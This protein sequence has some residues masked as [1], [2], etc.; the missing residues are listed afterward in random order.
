MRQTLL[1]SVAL[2][3]FLNIAISA[4]EN[5]KIS[6]LNP[7]KGDSIIYLSPDQ[8]M[9]ISKE[10]NAYILKPYY[11]DAQNT[12]DDGV[13]L[14]V[15]PNDN[16]ADAIEINEVHDIPISTIDATIDGGNFTFLPNIWYTYVS[17]ITGP[18]RIDFIDTTEDYPE[19]NLLGVYDGSICPEYSELPEPISLMGGEA[20]ET[21][22]SIDYS[23][24]VAI[25][26][27]L[28]GY[29]RDYYYCS[30]VYE[31]TEY[32]GDAVYSY[33]ASSD[34]EV[35]F[36]LSGDE[37]SYTEGS[38]VGLIIMDEEGNELACSH[39]TKF[40]DI[41][42][43]IAGAAV[44]NYP[45]AAG[46][47]YYLVVTAALPAGSSYNY[48]YTLFIDSLSYKTIDKAQGQRFM[49]IIFDAVTGNEYL[50][51]IGSSTQSDDQVLSIDAAPTPPV[52]D[53]CED[54]TD[55]G[56]IHAN[57]TIVF[58]GDNTGGTRECE[59]VT[60]CRDVWIK[61]TTEEPLDISIDLCGSELILQHN[62]IT[63]HTFLFKDCPCYSEVEY[64][65]GESD[66]ITCP[67]FTFIISWDNLPAGTYYYPVLLNNWL[68]GEYVVNVNALASPLCD[69]EA[70]FGKN[71]TT[72]D[73]YYWDFHL[74]DFEAGLGV[75]DKFSGVGEPIGEITWWGI[76]TEP[77]NEEACYPIEPQPFQVIFFDI[78]ETSP[79]I[80][81]DT[82][83]IY[84]VE[85]TTGMSG[86]YYSGVPQKKFVATLPENL[87][88]ENGWI[89]IIG[90]DGYNDC[91][92]HWQNNYIEGEGVTYDLLENR[93]TRN[94]SSF[95]F[96]LHRGQVSVDDTPAD[97]PSTYELQQNYPNPFNATTSIQ[98]SLDR[99]DEVT[100]TVYDILGRKIKTLY[101]G[102]IPA[103]LHSFIWDGTDQSDNAVAS[104]IYFYRLDSSENTT[105]KSMI[106]LK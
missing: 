82:A 62:Y 68:E 39:R 91:R 15:P 58:T 65:A 12:S 4:T 16:C 81:G 50:I 2:I 95:A 51:E 89:M 42:S 38:Y 54:A 7:T 94:N 45:V 30:C 27:N 37:Y 57:E 104:G 70:L 47:T 99:T 55:G 92:F 43:V 61:F 85:A 3:L 5:Q 49:D 73:D 36:I 17:S 79:Y 64:V 21:A 41:N 33:T 101:D 76:T 40:R 71:P 22:V 102:S 56:I 72:S 75:A 20:I 63:M 88:L 78:N 77:E 11:P 105:A 10:N 6:E 32:W 80:P 106:L 28:E 83:G 34:D 69:D 44:Y 90:N 9:V 67:D 13:A 86:Y 1:I 96:C 60:R 26:G 97:L 52:N 93:W 103:G 48:P 84:D 59:L 25:S 74:S 98:F 53:E 35:S 14:D 18:V 46:E 87:E 8:P 29:S 24:P 23:L 100:L 19:G 31:L 66:W